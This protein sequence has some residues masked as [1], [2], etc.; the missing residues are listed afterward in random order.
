MTLDSNTCLAHLKLLHAFQT[1]KEDIGYTDGLWGLWDRKAESDHKISIDFH[2]E[3]QPAGVASPASETK[4]RTTDDEIKIRLSRIR[5]KRWALF[6]A[7]AV[8]R[9]EAWWATL[10]KEMLREEHM[11][12]NS[13]SIYHKFTAHKQGMKWDEIM[14]PPL[15][16]LMV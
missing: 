16:V 7:R 4:K 15:D 10:P 14:L 6:V 13:G 11:A 1:L 5:E 12:K 3:T 2:K 8:D 9:Y